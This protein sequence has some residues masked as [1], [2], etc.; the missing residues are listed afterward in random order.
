M[1]EVTKRMTE[2]SPDGEVVSF[3]Y[4]LGKDKGLRKN[5]MAKTISKEERKNSLFA[6]A[7]Y[8]EI[9]TNKADYPIIYQMSN[10]IKAISKTGR[11]AEPAT[12]FTDE[13][14]QIYSPY[15]EINGYPEIPVTSYYTSEEM[16]DGSPTNEGMYFN[17][18]RRTY[19][20]SMDN[21]FIDA[22]PSFIISTIENCDIVGETCETVELFAGTTPPPLTTG[23]T[24]LTYSVNH[25][26]IPDQDIITTRIPMIKINGTDWMQFGG[27]HQKFSIFR[28]GVDSGVTQNADGTVSVAGKGFK[29]GEDFRTKR[30]NARQKNWINFD[31]EFD[32]DWNQS[33]SSHQIVFFSLHHWRGDVEKDF[34]VKYGYKYNAVTGVWEGTIDPTGSTNLTIKQGEA[35]FR[36]NAELSRRQVLSTIIGP[37]STGKTKNDGGVEY[38]V[39]S[40]GIV[41]YYFK[42]WYTDL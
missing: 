31:R 7:L 20:A 21:N 37:G 5:E 15:N 40:V 35:L 12:P 24:L 13:N 29:I 39:K 26:D 10:K 11:L 23:P 34:N 18:G 8:A 1:S 4:L 17:R 14:L 38:N 16:E 9:I 27:T 3:A 28:G 32:V 25:N 33:E 22:N 41:D 2:V 30:K 42:H 6:K 36:S 19:I